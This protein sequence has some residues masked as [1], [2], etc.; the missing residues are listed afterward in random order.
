MLANLKNG[1]LSKKPY[2]FQKKNIICS[3]I[4]NILWDDG[5]ILGYKIYSNKPYFF[6]IFLKYYKNNP[7]ITRIHGFSKPSRRFYMS[8]KE[9]WKIE[10]EV[11]LLILSTN[12]GVLPLKTCK[13]FNVGGEL[14]VYLK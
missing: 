12:K 1:Q 3:K 10:N 6:I 4:L 5:Y 11:G 8:V 13:R 2:I 9:I 7:C 14:L